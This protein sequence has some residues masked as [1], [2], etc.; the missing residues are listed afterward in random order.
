MRLIGGLSV[1]LLVAT[2]DSAIVRRNKRQLVPLAASCD[3]YTTCAPPAVCLSGQCQCAQPYLAVASTCVAAYPRLMTPVLTSGMALHYQQPQQAPVVYPGRV[4]QAAPVQYPAQMYHPAQPAYPVPQPSAPH[5]QPHQQPQP[6]PG[7]Y[8]PYLQPDLPPAQPEQPPVTYPTTDGSISTRQ[9][10]TTTTQPRLYDQQP[11]IAYP[12]EFCRIPDIVCVGGSVCEN[13]VCVCRRGEEPVN[14]QCQK[15]EVPLVP[16]SS[17]TSTIPPTTI[18]ST[19]TTTVA[20]TPLADEPTT[21]T[22]QST[23]T[24]ATTTTSTVAPTTVNVP[25]VV[26][27]ATT[28]LTTTETTSTVG[29]TT[30]TQYI[31]RQEE[32]ILATPSRCAN[33]CPPGVYNCPPQVIRVNLSFPAASSSFKRCQNS[34]DCKRGSFCRG[35]VCR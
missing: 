7:Y 11:S 19:S 26:T 20:S 2:C 6:Q 14:G 35:G 1:L 13:N 24:T 27:P 12:G 17:T 18:S 32:N 29:S 21:T 10:S 15:I 16:E 3:M 30:T 5:P 8:P 33:C 22:V 34:V 9:P 23:T 28:P 25:T 4:L 31:G